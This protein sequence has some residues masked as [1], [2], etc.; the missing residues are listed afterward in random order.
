MNQFAIATHSE[1]AEGYVKAV[2]FFL[3]GLQN[4]HYINAYTVSQEFEKD[5]LHLIDSIEGNIIVLTDI[6]NGSVNQVCAKHMSEKNYQLITGVNLPLVL[7]LVFHEE[8]LTPETLQHAV[9][10]AKTQM[11]YM[12][13]YFNKDNASQEDAD[14]EDL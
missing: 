2:D 5:F 9:E 12:N 6:A 10:D 8:D 1:L 7:E 14:E 11:I 13:T 4:I 3:S